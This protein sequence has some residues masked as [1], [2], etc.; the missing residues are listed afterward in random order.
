MPGQQNKKQKK[1]VTAAQKAQHSKKHKKTEQHFVAA[2]QLLS[3]QADSASQ[4]YSA[5]SACQYV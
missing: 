5:K 4:P 2:F 1:K 3:I